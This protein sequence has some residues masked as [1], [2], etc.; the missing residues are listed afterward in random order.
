MNQWTKT[1]TCWNDVLWTKRGQSPLNL[2]C[3]VALTPILVTSQSQS[4][5]AV[6]PWSRTCSKR[7]TWGIHGGD[8]HCR[9]I[10]IINYKWMITGTPWCWIDATW[11][12]P[13]QSPK[14]YISYLVG[15]TPIVATS[16]SEVGLSRFSKTHHLV[17][18]TMSVI[19]DQ[20]EASAFNVRCRTYTQFSC[21][22]ISG[23]DDCVF[24]CVYENLVGGTW[25]HF[26]Y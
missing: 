9:M 16:Q 25:T 15:L 7:G 6:R 10:S 24:V 22:Q 14:Q 21:R 11:T 3:F 18:H 5:F 12:N 4:E 8:I 2:A 20:S 13:G 23:R 26:F 17:G 19:V 1:R